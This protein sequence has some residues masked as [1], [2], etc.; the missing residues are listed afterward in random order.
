LEGVEI[1]YIA[2]SAM[3]LNPTPKTS[4][5]IKFTPI[6]SLIPSYSNGSMVPLL[7]FIVSNSLRAAAW[8]LYLNMEMYSIQMRYFGILLELTKNPPKI[9]K[10]IAKIGRIAMATSSLGT[11]TDMHRP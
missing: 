2:I 9:I 1:K 8:K 11:T 3:N 4:S 5:A 10:G 6:F 7:K